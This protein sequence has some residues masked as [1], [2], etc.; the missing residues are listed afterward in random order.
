MEVMF[1]VEARAGVD[2]DVT[3]V[4]RALHTEVRGAY[5]TGHGLTDYFAMARGTG[6]GV[7]SMEAPGP[8]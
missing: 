1:A 3:D 6:Q 5:E 7:V 8:S 2:V 4:V